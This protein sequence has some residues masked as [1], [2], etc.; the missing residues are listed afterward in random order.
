M[1]FPPSDDFFY[2]ARAF[3]EKAR[4]YTNTHGANSEEDC[5]HSDWATAHSNVKL[6]S[7]DAVAA[8]GAWCPASEV[9]DTLQ[10]S[11]TRF[12]KQRALASF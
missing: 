12:R 3:A 4:H 6:K 10:H 9:R 1:T 2:L 11:Q 7:A 5:A 8:A